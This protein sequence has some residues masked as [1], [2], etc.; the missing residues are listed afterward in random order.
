[1]D[2]LTPLFQLLAQAKAAPAAPADTGPQSLLPLILPVG[3][4][5][6]LYYFMIIRPERAKQATQR[7]KLDQLKKNDRVVTIG[8]IY[9]VIMDVRRDSDEVVLKIDEATNT[10]IKVTF[11]A[12]GRVVS[13]EPPSDKTA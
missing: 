9:G 11:G 4:A 1:L 2:Y 13:D 5:I 10:K 6:V 12:I 7:S 3:A 8:G